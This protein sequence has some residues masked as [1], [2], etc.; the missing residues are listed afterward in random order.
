[1]EM[2]S[3]VA[4]YG[5]LTP[6]IDWKLNT[7]SGSR[8]FTSPDIKFPTP[9]SRTPTVI[10]ALYGVDEDRSANLRLTVTTAH[11][12]PDEFNVVFNTWGDSVIYT[13]WVSWI[14][15]VP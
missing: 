10:V 8:S 6:E 5:Y 14:A 3:G 7:G 11:V 2:Q 4:S 15:Y 1:M 9:F 12:E 13:V